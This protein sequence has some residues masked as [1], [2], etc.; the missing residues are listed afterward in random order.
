VLTTR[1]GAPTRVAEAPGPIPEM[2]SMP[3]TIFLT[4]ATGFIGSRLARRLAAR[5]DR[6]RCLVRASSDT[7]DLERAGAEIVRGELTDVGTIAAALDG[8]DL[9]Y[10][11]AGAYALGPHVDPIAMRRTNV[12]GTRAFIAAVERA[13]TPRA[14]HVSTTAALAPASEGAIGDENSEVPPG[15]WF[16]SLYHR[17]KAEA[18]RLAR[19]A[20][21]RGTPL[22]VVCPANVYGP[23]D[24]GPNGDF[25]ADLLAGRVPGLLL[26]PGWYSY[27]HVDDV[28]EGLILAGEAGR[29]GEVYVLS[30]EDL[31]VNDFAQRVC[32]AAGRR[33]PALRF[34]APLARLSASA[35]DIVSRL[36][37]IRFPLTRETVD[38]SAGLRWLHSHAKATRELGWSP[39]PLAEGLPE[40][41]AWFQAGRP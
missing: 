5:G 32:A 27:V 26:R 39:R 25:I 30:G 29:D 13:G 23:G 7:T 1:P 9:A 37:G 21:A 14:V 11:L 41:I 31:S 33:A 19:E 20:Q 8:V 38:T 6:V 4:G 12:E 40:T 34:P 2:R 24:R 36:T 15:A 28:V 35:L 17:T 22:V 10:H 16:P 18:H 3:R